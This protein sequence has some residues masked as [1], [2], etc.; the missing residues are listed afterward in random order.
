[1]AW[2]KRPWLSFASPAAWC[3]HSRVRRHPREPRRLQV[4]VV[5]EQSTR[6]I[7]HLGVVGI[8]AAHLERD[9]D[10]VAV[11]IEVGVGPLQMQSD[12]PTEGAVPGR[13][14]EGLLEPG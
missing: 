11:A 4:G 8:R 2:S 5:P 12:Q 1:M 3:S 6:V 13:L 10:G 7:Q 14:T 9:R